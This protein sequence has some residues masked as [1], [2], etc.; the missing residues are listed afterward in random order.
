MTVAYWKAVNV[1]VHFGMYLIGQRHNVPGVLVFWTYDV[2][3]GDGEHLWWS[4]T[5]R[6]TMFEHVQ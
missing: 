5:Q 2:F 1:H 6:T 3:A 4:M